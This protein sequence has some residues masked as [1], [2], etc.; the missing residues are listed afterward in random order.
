MKEIWSNEIL[1]LRKGKMRVEVV[2][3]YDIC[4]IRATVGYLRINRI[5]CWSGPSYGDCLKDYDLRRHEVGR[6]IEDLEEIVGVV[7]EEQLWDSIT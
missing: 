2:I 3:R 7:I 5:L 4:A 6:W 1:H